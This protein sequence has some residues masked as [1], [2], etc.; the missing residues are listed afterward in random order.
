MSTF[1]I[2]NTLIQLCSENGVSGDEW[3]ASD[4]ALSMLKSYTDDCTIDRFGNVIGHV[5]ERDEN[6]PTLLLDAHI[7]QIGL[8]VTFIDEDG[9]I[10]VS[11]CGGVDR[12]VL[13]A[14]TVTVHGSKK[15]KGVI[16][17]L[18]PHVKKDGDKVAQ[19]DELV[20]DTGYSKE[21]LSEIVSL[22][23]RITVDNEP[24]VLL[25]NRI[26]APA[27][28]DRAGVVCILYALE[29]LKGKATKYNIDVSFTGQEETGERGAKI[30]AFN[31]NPEICLEMDVS[32]AYTPDSE[33]HKCGELSGGVMIGIAPSLSKR[34]SNELISIAKNKDIPYSLEVMS[35]ETGTNADAIGVAKGGAECCTLS[36][37]LRYM[38]TPV[39][40]VTPEDIEA[41]GRLIYEFAKEGEASAL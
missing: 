38:H 8:I 30:A 3:N 11:K 39:E 41:I 17:V 27:C 12:R 26:C 9:F 20:I 14:Q 15:I 40:V 10:R 7:D 1:D 6:K 31:L 36:I 18:P 5:G 32:F 24:A 34:L 19:I 35:G 13:A 23:D 22:G 25:N 16:S 28:D 29:L 33:K 2:K 37:P 21:E 4:L